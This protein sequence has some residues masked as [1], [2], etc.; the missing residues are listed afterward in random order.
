MTNRLQKA[1]E[2]LLSAWGDLR[3]DAPVSELWDELKELNSAYDE[4]YFHSSIGGSQ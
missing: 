2:E 1:I 3:S 4:S